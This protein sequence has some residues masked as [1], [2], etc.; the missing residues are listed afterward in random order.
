MAKSELE[1]EKDV[2][3]RFAEACFASEPFMEI[4]TKYVQLC[5]AQGERQRRVITKFNPEL[6]KLLYDK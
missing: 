1:G 4:G 5:F 3:Q 6:A 2:S